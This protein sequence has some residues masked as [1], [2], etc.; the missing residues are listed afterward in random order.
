[1]LKRRIEMTK[2]MNKGQSAVA[3]RRSVSLVTGLAKSAMIL[4]LR[5]AVLGPPF[6][7]S[8]P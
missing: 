8:L 7:N 2:S 6:L 4:V 3:I 1:M 5:A